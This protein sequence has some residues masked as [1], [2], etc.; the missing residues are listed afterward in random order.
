MQN[1]NGERIY[2]LST[3]ESQYLRQ[4]NGYPRDGSD[5]THDQFEP[6]AIP[7]VARCR[8]I[9]SIVQG[10]GFATEAALTSVDMRALRFSIL[11][12]ALGG[13]AVLLWAMALGMYKPKAMT[14]YGARD[15]GKHDGPL[16]TVSH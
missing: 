2:L 9:A 4:Q 6:R 14:P 7:P 8:S 15:S 5:P 16:P 10:D 12:H 11:G 3:F 13:L 1:V